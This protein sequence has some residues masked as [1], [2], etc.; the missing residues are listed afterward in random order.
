VVGTKTTP[1]VPYEIIGYM[2]SVN[3]FSTVIDP[4]MAQRCEVCHSQ[5]TGAAQAKAFP[6]GT[7]SGRLRRLPQ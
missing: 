6:V 2:N 3:N 4:A 7:D 5:T 1:G